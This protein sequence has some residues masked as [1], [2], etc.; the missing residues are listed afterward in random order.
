MH[1]SNGWK[2][3]NLFQPASGPSKEVGS[4]GGKVK[5][6][7]IAKRFRHALELAKIAA[8]ILPT[9]NALKVG[10]DVAFDKRFEAWPPEPEVQDALRGRKA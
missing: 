6:R 3:V 8:E 2:A 5:D 10:I 1:Y 7:E 9:A 4:G